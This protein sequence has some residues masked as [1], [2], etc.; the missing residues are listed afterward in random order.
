MLLPGHPPLRIYDL[1]A[2]VSYFHDQGYKNLHQYRNDQVTMNMM[3][4]ELVLCHYTI[5]APKI[6]IA[7]HN[8]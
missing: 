7:V 3:A 4:L 2:S 6:Q 1:I 5:I 8:T